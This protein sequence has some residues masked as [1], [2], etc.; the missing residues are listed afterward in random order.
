[1]T[2]DDA[3]ML[4]ALALAVR[5]QGHVAPNPLVGCVLVG[6]HGQRLGEGWHARYGEAHAEVNAVRDAETRHGPDAARGATAYVTLEPCSHTGKT[7]PCADLL[8]EKGVARVVVGRRDP[9][10]QVDGR[11]IARLRAAGIVVDESPLAPLAA[12][13]VEGFARRVAEGRPFVTLK[14]AQTLDGFAATASGDSRWVTGEA[15]RAHVHAVR[16][17]SDAVLVGAGTARADDPALTLRHGVEGVQ[18]LRV[19]LDRAAALP[20]TLRLFSDQHAGR[21]VAV[22]AEDAPSPAYEGRVATVRVRETNGHLD[23]RAVLRALASGDGLPGGRGVN[24][25]LVE[26]GPGL[27]GAVL[28][29]DFV[30]RLMVYVAPKLLGDGRRAL[31]GPAADAMAEARTF[32]AWSR[33]AVGDDTLFVG[34]TSLLSPDLRALL[35]SIFA[36]ALPDASP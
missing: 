6:A 15:A 33:H 12:R 29:A 24:S 35:P 11:G 23:L 20:A 28:A 27:A 30:D 31:P 3:W 34:E 13:L 7:P 1:M 9:N 18:P 17:A 5:G 14:V 25:V 10:P 8:V 36:H 4:R 19:V 22:L 26:A 16:A 21:T 32:A 2:P